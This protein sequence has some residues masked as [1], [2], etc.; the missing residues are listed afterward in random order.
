MAYEELGTV[1][2]QHM[3]YAEGAEIT[4]PPGTLGRY[5]RVNGN[6]KLIRYPDGTEAE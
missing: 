6:W 3:L 4:H 1:D 5:R 2:R